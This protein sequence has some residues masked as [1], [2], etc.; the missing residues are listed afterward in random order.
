M[1]E[2]ADA[3]RLLSLEVLFEHQQARLAAVRDRLERVVQQQMDIAS[4]LRW[5]DQRLGQFQRT[6][7]RGARRP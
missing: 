7:N 5:L 1:S 4:Q 2:P 3:D 6:L